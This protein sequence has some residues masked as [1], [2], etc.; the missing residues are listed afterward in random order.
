MKRILL[1]VA[2]VGGPDA[3]RYSARLC[4][5]PVVSG[6]GS[7]DATCWTLT[8]CEKGATMGACVV[9]DRV[10]ADGQV[11]YKYCDG[12]GTKQDS[13]CNGNDLS[14]AANG[15]RDGGGDGS[16]SSGCTISSGDVCPA[17]CSTCKKED[18]DMIIF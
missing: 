9:K 3:V 11:A 7:L 18:M 16:G 14:C 5:L 6:M 13:N 10:G 12:L 1:I 2:T 15:G 17:S 8:V 4:S